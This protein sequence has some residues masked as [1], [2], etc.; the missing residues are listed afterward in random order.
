MD[1]FNEAA[2]DS[3]GATRMT[4]EARDA[5]NAVLSLQKYE[6]LS[7]TKIPRSQWIPGY[8][9]RVTWSSVQ[10]SPWSARRVSVI[11]LAELDLDLF[12]QHFSRTKEYLF[13]EDQ[14]PDQAP[15]Y[16][17]WVPRLFTFAHTSTLYAQE[18]WAIQKISIEPI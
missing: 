16:G 4:Y 17:E 14:D 9:E 12:S 8:R 5:V 18:P 10:V 13:P 2:S 3:E 11:C 7:P 15:S 1:L 6:D